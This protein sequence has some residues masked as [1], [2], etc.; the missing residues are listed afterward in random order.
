MNISSIN[1]NDFSIPA[2]LNSS[3]ESSKIYEAS[4]S[5]DDGLLS[6]S[7]IGSGDA[8]SVQ[9]SSDT[10]DTNIQAQVLQENILTAFNE[11][12]NG[13]IDQQGLTNALQDLGVNALS[14]SEESTL[15][16]E[17]NTNTPFT[18]D[19]TAAL[20]ES[21]KGA[22]SNGGELKDYASMMDSVNKQ[23]QS[24]DVAEKLGAYTQ[25]L[26]N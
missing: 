3:E 14:K 10:P 15:S 1:N 6:A 11:F 17:G 24:S 16:K 18:Q 20:F 23:T 19:L 4:D 5:N 9:L 12:Q 7:E 13:S 22:N 25:N 2:A 8:A 26:R 21:I